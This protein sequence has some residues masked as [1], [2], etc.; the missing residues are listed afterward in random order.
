MAVTLERFVKRLIDSGLLTADEVA[1]FRDKLPADSHGESAQDLARALVR[2]NKLTAYQAQAVY[3]GKG[4]SLVL[5]NYVVLDKLGQGGMGMVLKAEHRVMER[6]VALKVLSPSV[7]KTPEAVR[8]FQRDVKAAARL[9]HVN[10]VTAHDADEAGGTHFL[11]M[12]YVKGTDLSALVREKGPLPIDQALSCMLQAARGLEYAHSQGVVHR[13]IKPSNLLL[14]RDGTVK[15]LDMGLARLDSA[16]PDQDRLT[17]TG[18]IMG[19]V[20][21]M[22]PEQAMD[23]KHADARADIYSLG[24]TLWYLLT[25]RPLYSGGTAVQKLMAHQ[26]KPIPSLCQACPLVSPE[27]E[28]VVAKMV[29]KTPETRYQTMTEVIADL[30]RC[31]AGPTTTPSVGTAL[32]EDSRFNEFLR[33]LEAT[34]GPTVAT[35]T[36]AEKKQAAPPVLQPTESWK[37]AEIHTDPQTQHSLAKP[38]AA[39]A[40]RT[41]HA[42]KRKHRSP[43][44]ARQTTTPAPCAGKEK[45]RRP[46]RWLAPFSGWFAQ[47][48]RSR[49][50]LMCP[51]GGAAFLLVLAA[52]VFF[53]QTKDGAIRVEINDPNI[54]VSIKGTEITLKQADQGKDVKLS[55]GEKILV[56]QRGDFQFETDK[57]ILKKGE[58]ITVRVELLAGEVQVRQGDKLIGQAKLPPPLAV[59]PF[60]AAT[61]KKHQ[62][63]WADYLGLTVEKEIDLGKGGKLTMVL[64]PPGEFLMGSSDEER[65]RFLENPKADND[66]WAL[67]H[68]PAE[69]PQHRARITRPFYLGKYEVTQAQWQVMTGNN[70]SQFKDN[71]AHPV[72]MVSWNDIQPF[73]AKLNENAS[74]A[75]MTFALPTEAQWEYACRA[76]TTTYWCSGDD[77][78]ELGQYAWFDSNSDDTTHPVGQ[79]KA[80]AFGLHDMHGNVCEHCADHY[81]V[82]YYAHA[83]VEDPIGPSEG[84]GHVGR[85][86][87][88]SRHHDHCRS[89]SRDNYS[90]GY[91]HNLNGFRLA[92]TIDTPKLKTVPVL[93][94]TAD[95]AQLRD[96]ITSADGWIDVI[97]LIDPQVDTRKDGADARAFKG[98]GWTIRDG[99]L[100]LTKASDAELI[101]FPLDAPRSYEIQAR[102]KPLQFNPGL[103]FFLPL[104]SHRALVHLGNRD[105]LNAKTSMAFSNETNR[106]AGFTNPTARDTGSIDSRK[107]GHLVSLQ[108]TTDDTTGHVRATVDGEPVIDWSGQVEL[109]FG[110]APPDDYFYVA[111]RPNPIAISVAGGTMVFEELRLRVLAGEAKLLRPADIDR[112]SRTAPPPAVAPFKEPSGRP[113]ASARRDYPTT[114][115]T[116][117]S[118]H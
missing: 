12:Q 61:A 23:T 73:L 6:L 53:V 9:E 95:D 2:E 68:I 44:P 48:P 100:A 109:L 37:S 99:V 76:G 110:E 67:E 20:D 19:T 69:G 28:A 1:A 107:E 21:F 105:G 75:K 56:V 101:V 88:W 103:D 36:A 7:T 66:Q 89:A 16:G 112:L 3:Q 13:D 4:K 60:D 117:S 85:G 50:A 31:Q 14:D 108:V 104:G 79:L 102:L 62:K 74:A 27:L 24:V 18:Q 82:D 10:I 46:P 94:G 35:Q 32:G 29:A 93:T 87:C 5:G 106:T 72:E 51:A 15:I 116:E 45:G 63:A 38:P 77:P 49:F 58:T 41:R 81:A 43:H 55:P 22:A 92:A 34:D 26:Q 71:P 25:R 42:K 97:S 52:I 11:V 33:G 39:D 65:A 59:A 113:H 78:D 54:E 30:E 40:K 114:G 83:P 17:G 91:A 84:S 57:L 47:L 90:W 86:G 70:P 98:D 96:T 115:R 118:G 80:N 8:R 111:G 64:I